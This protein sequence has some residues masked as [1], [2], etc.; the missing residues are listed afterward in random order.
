MKKYLS[1]ISVLML[2]F[3]LAVAANA[4]FGLVV[5]AQKVGEKPN[6]EYIDESW[7]E[8]VA[9][10]L[11]QLQRT[12]GFGTTGMKLQTK[13]TDIWKEELRVVTFV[14]PKTILSIFT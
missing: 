2:M 8:P 7:G 10:T 4:A 6:M 12:H 11:H 14:N 1:I 13:A 5:E 9:A 3:S